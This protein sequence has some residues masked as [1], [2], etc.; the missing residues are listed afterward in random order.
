MGKNSDKKKAPLKLVPIM[1]KPFRRLCID[2]VGPLNTSVNGN[3]YLITA[4]CQATKYPDAIPTRDLNSKS[5][6]HAMIQIFSKMGFPREIQCDLG[7]SFTSELTISFFKKYDTILCH[8]SLRH[9]Q[10]NS[11]ERIHSALKMI[12]KV[13]CIE[14]GED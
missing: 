1:S 7:T 10:S 4:L 14:L 13:L 12:L 9:P 5:V 11:M 6:V 3:K 2:A 8:S